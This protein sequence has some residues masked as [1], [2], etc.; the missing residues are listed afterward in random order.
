MSLLIN[1]IQNKLNS[2]LKII[3]IGQSEFESL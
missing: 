2:L 3:T 1:K